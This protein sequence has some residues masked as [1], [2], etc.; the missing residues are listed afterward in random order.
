[1]TWVYTNDQGQMFKQDPASDTAVEVTLPD[2]LAAMSPVVRPSFQRFA[3]DSRFATYV[4]GQYDSLAVFLYNGSLH[5]AG[6]TAPTTA[7]TVAVGSPS[8]NPDGKQICRY[9]YAQYSGGR[10]IAESNPSPSAATLSVSDASVQWSSLASTSPDARVTHLH[11]YRSQNGSLSFRVAVLT[12]G[13]TSYED[14][15]DFPVLVLAPTLPV[16]LDADGNEM[17]DLLARGTPPYATIIKVWHNR[18]WYVMPGVAGVRFSYLDEPESVNED[19]DYSQISIPGG[20][21]PLSLGALD[22]E[23]VV[24]CEDVAYSITGYGLSSFAIRKIGEQVRFIAPH[25]VQTMQGAILFA[26]DQGIMA[27]TGGGG[28]GFRTL[29]ARSFRAY[30]IELYAANAAAFENATSAVDYV[31]GDYM[32]SPDWDTGT[33]ILRG[34]YRPVVE[35]GESEPWWHWGDVR[36]RKTKSLGQLYPGTTRRGLI[37]Y[38]ECDGYARQ[39]DASDGTDD[40]DTHKKQLVVEHGHRWAGGNQ[41]G[42]LTAGAS[43][44]NLDWYG[45]AQSNT[46][47]VETY[48]GDET[49]NEATAPTETFDLAA[50]TDV[51]GVETQ[52]SSYSQALLSTAG[53]GVT[54]QIKVD[55]PVGVEHRGYAVQYRTGPQGRA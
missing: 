9:T 27:Y 12:L 17:D 1:V 14:N 55:Y 29:M 5:K 25:S 28:N 23:L 39:E 24:F 21:Y 11:L 49:A 32:F 15:T 3:R 48:A 30:W 41:G 6:L 4:A 7:P 20:E 2:G 37:T 45:L 22:D 13:T 8:G 47:T 42:D 16:K 40:G 31:S 34:Y 18:M 51:P 10:L 35:D 54:V 26:S 38:G 43:F 44:T 50:P 19:T 53:K 52:P 36:D 33:R 46:I